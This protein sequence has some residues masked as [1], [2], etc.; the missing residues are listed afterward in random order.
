MRQHLTKLPPPA[1]TLAAIALLVALAGTS[2]GGDGT[3]E[4][5]HRSSADQ[6]SDKAAKSGRPQG[7]RA[8]YYARCS[9]KKPTMLS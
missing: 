6:G 7:V 5:Q 2:V 9:S 8:R 3:A 4:K 1:S